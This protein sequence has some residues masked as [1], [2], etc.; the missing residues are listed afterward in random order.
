MVL[1]FRV[2]GSFAVCALAVCLCSGCA[3]LARQVLFNFIV[4]SLSD[5]RSPVSIGALENATGYFP[6]SARLNARLAEA[7]ISDPARDL[8]LA[9]R[10]IERA[11]RLSPYD[12]RLLV[13]L[14]SVK[15][16]QQDLIGAE[17]AMRDAARLAPSNIDVRW[18]LAN[19]L[20]RSGKI[21]DSLVEF[22]TA[23]S[24][25]QSLM[26]VTLDLLWRITGGDLGSLE[27]VAPATPASNMALASF[28][29]KQGRAQ[30]A[31][32]IFERIDR[33]C[34]AIAPP[35]SDFINRLISIGD[36]GQARSLW[37]DT[38]AAGPN[39]LERGKDTPL[40]WNGGFESD[41]LSGLAQFDWN[42]SDSNYA[43]VGFDNGAA[44]QGNRSLRV[45]FKGKDTTRLDGEIKQRLVLQAGRQYRIEYYAKTRNLVTTEGPRL[46]MG[47][48]G[49]QGWSPVGSAIA[50]GTE[51]WRK[52][53]LDFVVP[54]KR[55]KAASSGNLAEGREK[56][57]IGGTGKVDGKRSE[58]EWQSSGEAIAVTVKL[59]RIPKYSYDEPMRGTLWLDDFRIVEAGRE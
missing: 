45:E 57:A 50:A 19:L 11:T 40:V 7:E 30:E 3:L 1:E 13:V 15:E 16:S 32:Q 12:Y 5:S 52:M 56:T 22:R 47:I 54:A 28:L 37:I 42:L 55:N 53:E 21:T 26:P 14:A 9:S 43:A 2:K 36:L 8:G 35:S 23:I 20:L 10:E 58:R 31:A 29:L 17:S 25:D 6:T 51:D 46:A 39:S 38:V 44:H 33:A 34:R 59:I 48:D 18:R 27:A 4:F 41:P 49:E 24:G